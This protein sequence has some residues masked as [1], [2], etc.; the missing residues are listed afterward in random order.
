M[1]AP[2][3]KRLEAKLAETSDRTQ[4]AVI[5]AHIACYEARVGQFE[6]AERRRAELRKEFSDGHSAQVSILIMCLEG[7]LLYFKDLDRNARDR[8]LRAN[9]LSVACKERA[10][11]ALSS[12]WLAHIDFNHGRY[13]SMATEAAKCM[14]SLD[15]D[16]G[17]A[18]SRIALVLGDAFLYSREPT[19]ARRWYEHARVIANRIGDQAA[20]GA[21]TYNRAALHVAIARIDRLTGNGIRSD[22]ELASAEVRSAANYQTLAKLSSLDHLLT[23][24][25]IGI[26]MLEEK[27]AE[28]SNAITELLAAEAAPDNSAEL[29][30]LCA[31]QA[32]C[33]YRIGQ[34]ERAR[35]A[36]L[37][38][39]SIQSDNF[40]PDDRAL[41]FDALGSF[42]AASGDN[43]VADECRIGLMKALEEHKSAVGR[44]AQFI[45]AF[46]GGPP[47]T[48]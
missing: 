34:S 7:L 5:S 22:V 1:A 17:S 46:A 6:S 43:A 3:V 40:D 28:A 13:E 8:L 9:L 29:A 12:A 31:D 19:T 42:Y 45:H 27:F 20:I 32:W 24:A 11:V 25:S 41:I 47:T 48:Q 33:L 36:A 35:V 4:R 2:L 15:A 18:G 44:L 23:S 26:M 39:M 16:D 38:A 21:I 14:D 37:R 10:L 30:L